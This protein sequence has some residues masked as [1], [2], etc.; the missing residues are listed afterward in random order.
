M[1]EMSRQNGGK[2]PLTSLSNSDFQALSN[3]LTNLNPGQSDAQYQANV[4]RTID[5]Y[6]RAY[7]GAG[8]RDLEGDLDPSKRRKEDSAAPVIKE[9]A[10]PAPKGGNGGPSRSTTF[11]GDGGQGGGS[12]TLATGGTKTSATPAMVG[13]NAKVARMLRSG[14]SMRRSATTWHGRVR[15]PARRA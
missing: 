12:S 8:G 9:G 5:L 1:M 6:T 3:S 13:V 2:N 15:T 10:P 4:Q 14:A 7:Q 11:Y